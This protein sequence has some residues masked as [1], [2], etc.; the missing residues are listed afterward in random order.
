MQHRHASLVD[1]HH[2][3]DHKPRSLFNTI[4]SFQKQ[5]VRSDTGNDPLS[6]AFREVETF[7]PAEYDISVGIRE[8]TSNLEI[9]MGYWSTYMDET[10]ANSIIHTFH[11]AIN[12]IVTQPADHI[13]QIALAS[14]HDIERLEYWNGN[15]KPRVDVCVHSMVSTQAKQTPNATAIEAWDEKLTYAELDGLSNQLASYLCDA[16]VQRGDYVGLCFSKS[17][18]ATVA[19]LAVLKAGGVC[20]QFDPEWLHDQKEDILNRTEARTILVSTEHHSLF[21]ETRAQTLVIDRVT[22]IGWP[23]QYS[24]ICTATMPD[25]GAFVLFTSGSTGKPKGAIVP[26]SA[27]TSSSLAHGKVQGVHSESR[28]YQFAPYTFDVGMADTFTTLIYGGCICVPSESDRLSDLSRS[29]KKMKANWIHLTP[30]VSRLLHPDE[31]PELRTILVGGEALSTD[32]GARW[33]DRCRLIN[34]YGSAE[35]S[36]TSACNTSIQP[37]SSISLIGNPVGTR[38]WIVDPTNHNVLLP[39]GAVGEILVEGPTLAK[40]YL[41]DQEKTKSA[42][43]QDVAWAKPSSRRFYKTGDLGCWTSQGS[44]VFSSRKD[45]TVKLCGVMVDLSDI[46]CVIK[47][48]LP[49]TCIVATEN[50]KVSTAGHE[51]QLIAFVSTSNPIEFDT[52]NLRSQVSNILPS[53]MVPQVIVPLGQMP[54]TASGKI[55]RK[56]LRRISSEITESQLANYTTQGEKHHRPLTKLEAKMAKLWERVLNLPSDSITYEDSFLE[57]GGDSLTAMKLVALARGANINLTVASVFRQQRLSALCSTITPVES[58]TTVVQTKTLEPFALIHGSISEKAALRA[59]IAATLGVSADDIED[60]Y[61]VTSFQE[62][63][64]ASSVKQPGAYV[65]QEAIE[66]PESICLARFK[67]AWTKVVEYLSILRTRIVTTEAY[68]MIQALVRNATQ[69]LHLDSTLD[70]YLSADMENGMGP[71]TPLS[72]VAIVLDHAVWG[73]HILSGQCPMRFMMARHAL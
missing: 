35:C 56:R 8:T 10:Q 38:I 1:I 16:Y 71:G 58:A 53:Y 62:S 27:M 6:L 24:K 69:W 66:I 7:D 59:E 30:T 11:T 49:S 45:A 48:L 65:L 14:P 19:S 5:M 44:L 3:L 15:E 23:N 28:V 60:A 37:Q 36:V 29:I 22:S 50:T 33:A 21:T 46:E 54:M 25:D 57:V 52:V 9:L 12:L 61:P 68:G 55:D 41:E 42:F 73:K 40:G 39:I 26:H 70:A 63:V 13:S 34:T 51:N 47:G 72:R 67:A 32:V 17:A 20:V 18:W 64:M 2:A 4:L 43:I 31:L